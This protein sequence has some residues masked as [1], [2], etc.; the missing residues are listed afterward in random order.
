MVDIDKTNIPKPEKEEAGA[1]P[2]SKAKGV[3]RP[4]K[5]V[6]KDDTVRV[7]KL[8]KTFTNKS[9]FTLN[10]GA[11]K[12]APGE[13]RNLPNAVSDAIEQNKNVQLYIKAKQ[14]EIK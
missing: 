7:P 4:K 10:L 2:A 14:L 9:N 6:S 8:T 11:F 13:K 3:G 5:V 12:L 1:K